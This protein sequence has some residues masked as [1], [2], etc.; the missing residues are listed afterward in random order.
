VAAR[1]TSAAS[2]DAEYLNN[3]S[4]R[5]PVRAFRDR[6]EGT[7]VV[8]V[9]VLASGESGQI[10]LQKSSGFDLLDQAAIDTIKKWRFKPA[11]AD[12]QPV[13][14]WVSVPITFR[15]TKR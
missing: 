5:Y 12:G 2:F 3:P 11:M 1:A 6:A 10:V 14:Q 13:S 4:P 15:L 8:R 9:E 7:V